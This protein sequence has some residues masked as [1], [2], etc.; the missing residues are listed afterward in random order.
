[1]L[2][3]TPPQAQTVQTPSTPQA[4]KTLSNLNALNSSALGLQV[5]QV[6]SLQVHAV[7]DQQVQFSLGNQPQKYITNLPNGLQ[8]QTNDKLSAQ[9]QATHPE[10]TLKI[11]PNKTTTTENLSHQLLRQLL[12]NQQPLNQLLP[13]LIQNSQ[14]LPTS[15]QAQITQLVD[16][17]F[18]PQK[19]L[20]GKDLQ[21]KILS[22]GLF[23]ENQ[24]SKADTK[25]NLKQ[26]FKAQLL[27]LKANLTQNEAQQSLN[28]T[29]NKLLDKVTLQQV[30]AI[31]Q[32]FLALDMPLSPNTQLQQIQIDIRK[33]KQNQSIW[34]VV[35][36]ISLIYQGQTSQLMTKIHFDQ[37][38]FSIIFWSDNI[39]FGTDLASKFDRLQEFFHVNQLTIKQLL[40]SAQPIRANENLQKVNLIDI[41]V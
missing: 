2:K 32:G 17:L 11:L 4:I 36:D 5:G 1:M 16:S 37:E 10:L 35:L 24:L 26:D 22:S 6:V 19:G 39:N 31:Q 23:L 33:S 12:P 30:Q 28:Q 29:V 20:Q 14:A 18:K 25:T 21:Q 15:L 27:Q 41:R 9:V 40:M 8:P 34:E 13:L 7:R 3:P 38:A